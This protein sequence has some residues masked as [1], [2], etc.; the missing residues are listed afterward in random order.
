MVNPFFVTSVTII[1]CPEDPVLICAPT[2]A[3]VIMYLILSAVNLD[4]ETLP[5]LLKDFL[6]KYEFV[7]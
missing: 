3:F 6:D 1:E 2:P 4:F 7:P 5:V